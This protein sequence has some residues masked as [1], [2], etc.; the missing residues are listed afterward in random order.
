MKTLEGKYMNLANFYKQNPSRSKEKSPISNF[1]PRNSSGNA[2]RK[3]A[4]PFAASEV[5][6][7]DEKTLLRELELQKRELENNIGTIK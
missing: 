4:L 2:R 5:P 3:S 6:R 1:S 7:D